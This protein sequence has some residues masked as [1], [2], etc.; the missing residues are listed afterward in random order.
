VSNTS[1]SVFLLPALSVPTPFEVGCLANSRRR[2]EKPSLEV[3]FFGLGV[4][5]SF[6][7]PRV[8]SFDH[9]A[10]VELVIL[11]VPVAPE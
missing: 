7:Q 6:K 2:R 8:L 11:L 10:V 1:S 4:L 3:D 9:M 5:K